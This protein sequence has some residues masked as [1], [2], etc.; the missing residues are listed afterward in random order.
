LIK[1]D[2]DKA[3]ALDKDGSIASDY[4]PDTILQGNPEGL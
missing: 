3:T 4:H 1:L 2:G